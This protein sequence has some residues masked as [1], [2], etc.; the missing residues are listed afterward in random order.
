MLLK[1]VIGFLLVMALLAG[2]IPGALA[3]GGASMSGPSVVRAGDVITVSFSAGGGIYGGSGTVS[4]D[5]SQLTLLSYSQVIGGSWVVEFNGNNFVFYDNSMA[6]PINGITTIFTATFQVS[7]DLATGAGMSVSA[8]GVTLS[9]GQND[10]GAGSPNYSATIAPPLSD[11]CN[12]ATLTVDNAAISPAFSVDNTEYSASVPYEVS[13]LSVTATAEHPGATVTIG[14]TYLAEAATTPVWITVTAETGATKTYT[15]YVS[16]PR[17]P[18]YVESDNCNLADLWV[19]GFVLSPAFSVDVTKYYVWVPYET[20][21]VSVGATTE[22]G[23]ASVSVDEGILL[24]P[25]KGT[26]IP[27]TVTAENGAQ[28]VYT[29][30]A[31]RAPAPEDVERYL[32]CS[33]DPE[34]EPTEPVTEPV[35]EPEP[36]VPSEEPSEPQ[37]IPKEE[38]DGERASCWMLI[39]AAALGAAAGA[40]G[41]A[42][43]LAWCRKK[44]EAPKIGGRLPEDE[45]GA[46]LK[47]ENGAEEQSETGADTE[48]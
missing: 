12:L 34:P 1:K 18:N 36:T 32:N 41:C 20:E 29:I 25:G 38:P 14:D 17:D 3:A 4:Y 9:D 13:Y 37:E 6:S 40:T 31:V 11:N 22:D 8:S 21:T 19:E 7:N 27:V 15:I 44:K 28:K 39:L 48:E 5:A 23:R 45:A 2:L 24:E 42:G 35:T 43:A 47:E 33:H 46:A 26:D 16:R 30:T 10:I